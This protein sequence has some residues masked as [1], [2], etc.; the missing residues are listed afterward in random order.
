MAQVLRPWRVV[1]A[2]LAG[3]INRHP[4][5]AIDSIRDENRIFVHVLLAIELKGRRV[6]FAGMTTGPDEACIRQIGRNLTDPVDGFFRETRFC[7]L[8]RDAKFTAAFRTPLAGAGIESRKRSSARPTRT[9]TNRPCGRASEVRRREVG[10]EA[11]QRASVEELPTRVKRS[12]PTLGP[13]ARRRRGARVR[14]PPP[15]PFA[16]PF[17][18][19]NSGRNTIGRAPWWDDKTA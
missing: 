15:P 1:L 14:F 13:P 19:G 10:R 4:Q 2:A 5:V 16:S 3:W 7:L 17:I 18:V 9:I 11:A 12:A 8:N 6:H